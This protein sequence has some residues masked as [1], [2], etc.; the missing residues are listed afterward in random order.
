V[1]QF[2]NALGEFLPHFLTYDIGI[3]KK[4]E[5]WD[6]NMLFGMLKYHIDFFDIRYKEPSLDLKNTKIHFTD[7]FN[8]PMLKV[9]FPG[10]KH[11]MIKSKMKTNSW[12][13]P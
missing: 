11:W 6:V 12:L 10:V 3:N 7:M 9:K 1:D 8:R 2:K 13:L 5:I 4:E